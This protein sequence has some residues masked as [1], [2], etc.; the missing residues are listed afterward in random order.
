[1]SHPCLVC[2]CRWAI[3]I[4]AMAA[5]SAG[6]AVGAGNTLVLDPGGVS[7]DFTGCGLT[8]LTGPDLLRNG[9]MEQLDAAQKLTD[10]QPDWYVW[11]AVPDAARQAQIEQRVKPHLQWRV[12]DTGAFA[13]QHAARL[14]IPQPAFSPDDPSGHEFCAMYHQRVV[15]PPLTRPMRVVLTYRY[16]GW[17]GQDM[18]NCRAYTRITFYDS[19][20]PAQAK[21]TRVYDQALF[22]PSNAWKP[23]QLV[24]TVPQATRVLDVRIAL[25]GVGEVE[26]D[27]VALHQAQE[28]DTGLSA[29]LMPGAMLDNRIC[30]SSG[31]LLTMIFG[32]R[33]GDDRKLD[34]P[35]LVLQ[36]PAWVE[37]METAPAVK[38]EQTPL[39]DGR[40]EHRFDLTPLRG[41]IRGSD[42]P[43]PWH[44]WGGLCLFVRTGEPPGEKLHE[45]TYWMEDGTTRGEAQRF[46]LQVVP[47]LPTAERP[48]LFR[49]GA[50]PFGIWSAR[51]PETVAGFGHTY[52]RVGFNCVHCSPSPIGDD[53]GKRGI[54]RFTQP[55][56]N[57]YSMGGQKPDNVAFRD[58]EGKAVAGAICPTEVYRRGPYF[59][60]AIVG[61]MLRQLLVTDR[62]ADQLMCNWEPYMYV[63]KGCYCS[64][65]QEEF[66]A[67]SKLPAA[68]VEATWPRTVAEKHGEVLRRFRRWQHAQ[69]MATLEETVQAL[70]KEAGREM[71][72]IPELHYGLL[73][74]GWEK[75]GDAGE[76]AAVDYLDKLPAFNA[77]GPYNWYVF[78]RGPYEYVRGLHLN[79]HATALQVKD[80]LRS[81]LP[82]DKQP[83]L[84]AFPYGTYEGATEPEAIGFELQTYFLDGYRGAIVYLYPGGYDARHWRAIAAANTQ[85]ARFEPFVM[86]GRPARRHKVQP[87]TPLPPPDPRFLQS[88]CMAAADVERWQQASLLQSWEFE[89]DDQRLFAVGNFW[90]RGECFFRLTVQAPPGKYALTEPATGRCFSQNT[91]GTLSAADLSKGV[92]LHAGALRYAFFVLEPYRTGSKQ[93]TIVRPQQM[94]TARRER[95]PA[96]RKAAD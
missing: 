51:Q 42:F 56:A 28:Q 37:V 31:D 92:L 57:G 74:S 76:F 50:H 49:T 55:F 9:G 35:Q 26:F 10:W 1:M 21:Q 3:A 41:N 32:F 71:H 64:R 53:L 16:R 62:K 88:G 12:Q 5:L 33:N 77:W 39:A 44:Q 87:V 63:G 54:E 85:I 30:L 69:F 89:R 34:R 86:Q 48:K 11:L 8:A 82:A 78:G 95:E 81:R 65:C 84:Y 75:S 68:E 91:D 83:D 27:D 46:S 25:T 43:Y 20:N 70:G 23:G 72:F 73:T 60:S 80:F 61:D 29:R 45:A 67:F 66:Q 47:S 96:I 15:L 36:L 7:M 40:T 18:P 22:Q 24:T 79:C 6:A 90:E 13:G 38:R 52:E 14:A 19:E 93:D 17:C 59:Q 2:R 94:E 58:I 4:S